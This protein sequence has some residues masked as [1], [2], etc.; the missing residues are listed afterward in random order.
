ML[1]GQKRK[2]K[3]KTDW[4]GYRVAAQLKMTDVLMEEKSRE[5]TSNKS[6]ETPWSKFYLT[7]LFPYLVYLVFFP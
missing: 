4:Y 2:K 7:P 5:L 6:V 1:T 3:E